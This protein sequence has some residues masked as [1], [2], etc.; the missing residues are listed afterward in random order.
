[1]AGTNAEGLKPPTILRIM[2]PHY[3]RHEDACVLLPTLTIVTARCECGCP[4][5]P[6]YILSVSFLIW[7]VGIGFQP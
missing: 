1:M 3:E 7:S 4:G 5:D 6:I 2:F